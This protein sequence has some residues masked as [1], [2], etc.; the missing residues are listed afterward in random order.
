M[1]PENPATSGGTPAKTYTAWSVIA[2]FF[3]LPTALA[4]LF[5][6][7]KTYSANLLG[8][9]ALAEQ[10]SKAVRRW[11]NITGAIFI[12]LLVLNVIY[13]ATR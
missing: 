11:L 3:F 13:S 7:G 4:A 5:Q 9:Y 2:V 10:S 8:D 12:V 1:A 6:S